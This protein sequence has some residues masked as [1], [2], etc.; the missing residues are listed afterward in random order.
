MAS[1]P[2]LPQ[3][4]T[5]TSGRPSRPTSPHKREGTPF[6]GTDRTA[7]V[8]STTPSTPVTRVFSVDPTPCDTGSSRGSVSTVASGRPQKHKQVAS[9]VQDD[10]ATAP[11][12]SQSTEH[13]NSTNA[14][15]NSFHSLGD[16]QGTNPGRKL[17]IS[18]PGPIEKRDTRHNELVFRPPFP[19]TISCSKGNGQHNILL[20]GMSVPVDEVVYRHNGTLGL[21]QTISTEISKRM[22]QEDGD[23]D[24]SRDAFV[25]SI[26]RWV[27]DS[28]DGGPETSDCS[29]NVEV[30]Q[31][32]LPVLDRLVIPGPG[33]R[34]EFPECVIDATELRRGRCC[35]S[36]A[37]QTAAQ[38]LEHATLW[39]PEE[40]RV[41]YDF[42]ALS[43]LPR[44]DGVGVIHD[45]GVGVDI[46]R[47]HIRLGRWVWILSSKGEIDIL[48]TAAFHEA[49][50]LHLE[51]WI[52][53]LERFSRID[54]ATFEPVAMASLF[55]ELENVIKAFADAVAREKARVDGGG[56]EDVGD[57]SSP[58]VGPR[59]EVAMKVKAAVEERE[60]IALEDQ[61]LEAFRDEYAARSRSAKVSLLIKSPVSEL[62]WRRKLRSGRE[63]TPLELQLARLE[64]KYAAMDDG[65]PRGHQRRSEKDLPLPPPRPYKLVEMEKATWCSRRIGKRR[66]IMGQGAGGESSFI[67]EPYTTRQPA[68]PS[69]PLQP[70]HSWESDEDSPE[71]AAT[72]D[73]EHQS[74][75]PKDSE[76]YEFWSKDFA[77]FRPSP[78]IQKLQCPRPMGK[79]ARISIVPRDV[80]HRRWN[81]LPSPPDPMKLE[82]AVTKIQTEELASGRSPLLELA[83]SLAPKPPKSILARAWQRLQSRKPDDMA[84]KGIIS[85]PETSGVPNFGDWRAAWLGE[86]GCYVASSGDS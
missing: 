58:F 10:K 8:V 11:D 51:G 66:A 76:E 6:P 50:R 41:L 32:K 52:T 62:A 29:S 78:W 40:D 45:S 64:A 69:S 73:W 57:L 49:K 7:S 75:P 59:N 68:S 81:S 12:S 34:I 80:I 22:V 1:R 63:Q 55:A 5:T 72:W 43:S 38:Y 2:T 83:A 18:C 60:R 27:D 65:L 53:P 82:E 14:S 47:Q 15:G 24:D 33:P 13:T 46:V 42:R 4:R 70:R 85:G 26:I 9:L 77:A 44:P 36:I 56:S 86:G 25:R 48:R 67:G 84:M 30:P 28:R 17:P 39:L 31:Y 71:A 61:A 74:S 79:T 21:S 19:L 23:C 37:E 16:K 3:L 54:M 35:L 20:P